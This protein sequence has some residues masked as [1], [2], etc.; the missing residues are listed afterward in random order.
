[1][2]CIA[3]RILTT[4]F[5]SSK[6]INFFFVWNRY[7]LWEKVVRAKPVCVPSFLPTILPEILDVWVLQVRIQ[8]LI[9]ISYKWTTSFFNQMIWSEFLICV[10]FR[11]QLTLN[12][13][14]WDF[15]VIWVS[16]KMFNSK[17]LWRKSNLNVYLI[18]SA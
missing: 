6:S 14:M 7:C 9:W 11:F 17:N 16:I 12:T 4:K 8:I 1:M 18:V 5:N 13:L 15:L 2:C 3:Y 10:F